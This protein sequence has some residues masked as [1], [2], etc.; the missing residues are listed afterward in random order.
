MSITGLGVI[1]RAAGQPTKLEEIIIEEPGEGEVLVR[2]QASGVCH[3]D[4]H[5]KLG[6]IG[7][8]FPY[9]LGHE[10]AGIIESVGEGVTKPKVG[11]YVVLAWLL[12]V[13]RPGTT[14]PVLRQPQRATTDDHQDGQRSTQS[15]SRYR[16][17]L[18]SHS[19]VSQTGG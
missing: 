19:G 11:D 2:I 10:G 18:H 13:L 5:Y 4:L 12:P 17:L 9:L 14:Q 7:N 15:R 3:T 6:A 8:D 16:H 1:S